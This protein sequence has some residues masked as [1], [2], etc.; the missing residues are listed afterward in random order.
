M[1]PCKCKRNGSVRFPVSPLQLTRWSMLAVHLLRQGLVRTAQRSHCQGAGI[2]FCTVI[3][4]CKTRQ[5]SQ[6]ME[7]SAQESRHPLANLGFPHS[8]AM[9][10]AF[11]VPSLNIRV[12]FFFLFIYLHVH[13]LF[14]SFLPPLP[15]PHNIRVLI[16]KMITVKLPILLGTSG[17]C[18]QS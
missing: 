14:G 15:H 8:P 16:S 4:W 7:N 2:M 13:T 1:V 18:L 10:W 5:D 12:F 11:R 9:F 6:L 3:P 17:S